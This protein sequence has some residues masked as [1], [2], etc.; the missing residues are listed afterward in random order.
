MTFD[1][2]LYIGLAITLPSQILFILLYS[3][4]KFGA[5]PW[6][7]DIVGRALFYRSIASIF[8]IP[9]VLGL[10]AGNY[11]EGEY[12]TLILNPFHS[13]FSVWRVLSYMGVLLF[14]IASHSE[15]YSLVRTRLN[16]RK[17]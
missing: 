15:T 7:K 17:S 14:I 5:G 2:W 11:V 8:F 9:A 12:A 16:S 6:W 10:M 3:I 4:P 13:E 1:L